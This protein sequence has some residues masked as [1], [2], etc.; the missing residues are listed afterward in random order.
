MGGAQPLVWRDPPPDLGP[1]VQAFVHRDERPEAQVVRLLPEPRMSIQVMAASPYWLRARDREAAW[2]QLP[3]VALWG[4]RHTWAYGY[5]EGHVQAFGVVLTASGFAALVGRPASGLLDEVAALA[6][7]QP[8]L[9][10]ALEPPGAGGL[11]PWL[12]G[13][14][15]ALRLAFADAP[16]D[17]P[18]AGV[19]DLLATAESDMVAAAAR[20][21]GLSERQFRRVFRDRHGVSP[22]R[23]QRAVRVDRMIRQ[24]HARPWEIDGHADHPI[25]FA[26]QPHAI[27]EFKALTGLTPQQYVRA[28]A[29][30]D[31]AMRSVAAPGVPGPTDPR[32]AP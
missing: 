31:A 4:P 12:A 3:P 5:A 24:L 10:A 14:V 32:A 21:A 13:A 15:P 18:L 9:S 23:Y 22:K 17:D 30:G 27:R 6:G 25:A 11:E 1:W 28:K 16:P 19:L 20:A 7:V 2:R 8:A 29:R 26:D